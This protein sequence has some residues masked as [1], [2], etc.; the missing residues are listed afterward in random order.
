LTTERLT[1]E[2]KR[3]SETPIANL[4]DQLRSE[5][6]AQGRQFRR[7]FPAIAPASSGIPQDS[8]HV[9]YIAAGAGGAFIIGGKIHHLALC[10][11]RPCCP[12]RPNQK[13]KILQTSCSCTPRAWACISGITLAPA[14]AKPGGHSR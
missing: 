12:G 13:Q 1:P 9:F 6:T 11:L 3:K 7:V 4:P 8:G 5:N 14:D 2:A 10:T